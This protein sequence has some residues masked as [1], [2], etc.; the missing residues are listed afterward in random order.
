MLEIIKKELEQD[1]KIWKKKE[2]GFGGWRRLTDATI[3]RLQ[4]YA[5]VAI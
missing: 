3:D 5:G 1:Y 2:K 4:N